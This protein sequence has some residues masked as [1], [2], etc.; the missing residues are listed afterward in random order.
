MYQSLGNSTQTAF[1][2]PTS[3]L[4]NRIDFWKTGPENVQDYQVKVFVEQQTMIEKDKINIRTDQNGKSQIVISD[5]KIIQEA[6]K[7][8]ATVFTVFSNGQLEIMTSELNVNEGQ[9][10]AELKDETSI[11]SRDFQLRGFRVLGEIP[12][13]ENGAVLWHPQD[14]M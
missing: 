2:M 14:N 11:E 7:L 9:L 3:Y 1:V 5:P 4:L 6:E 12:G 13:D 10:I 8:T